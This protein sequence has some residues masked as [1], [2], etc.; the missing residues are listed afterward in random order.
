MTLTL[1][2]IVAG[3]KVSEDTFISWIKVNLNSNGNRSGNQAQ[4]LSGAI[5]SIAHEF[6]GLNRSLIR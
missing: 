3:L 1:I 5:A 6:S 2:K 4:N